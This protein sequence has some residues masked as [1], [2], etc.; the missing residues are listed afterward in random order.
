VTDAAKEISD[1]MFRYAELF[2][3]GSFD[4]FAALFEHGRWHKAQPGAAAARRWIDDN[5]QLY[6]GSPRTKHVTTNVVV[7][8]DDPSDTATAGAYVMVFQAGPDFPLQPIFAGRYRD[9]LARIDG[10]WWFTERAIVNDLYGDISHH[11]R[12]RPPAESA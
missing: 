10:H 9:R 11:V 12:Y 3:T 4:E 6:D 7:D 2:D 1:L 8:V 5:V